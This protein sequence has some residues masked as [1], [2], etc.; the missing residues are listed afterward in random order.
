MMNDKNLYDRFL[1]KNTM[2]RNA[3]KLNKMSLFDIVDALDGRES[4]DVLYFDHPD[5]LIPS[6]IF[7]ISVE[8][9]SL[10]T[11]NVIDVDKLR[12][13]SICKDI[14]IEDLEATIEIDGTDLSK[15]DVL[16]MSEEIYIGQLEVIKDNLHDVKEFYDGHIIADGDNEIEDILNY[17]INDKEICTRV[18][19]LHD[20]ILA[21]N[22]FVFVDNVQVKLYLHRDIKFEE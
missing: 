11:I 3:E 16:K 2:G 15:S 14:S 6:K 7:R 5:H 18:R 12:K 8:Y 19:Y 9:K 4:F 21:K 10:N 1:K 22:N 17:L 20:C 13:H